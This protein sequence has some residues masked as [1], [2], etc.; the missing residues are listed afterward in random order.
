MRHDI[1]GDEEPAGQELRQGQLEIGRVA[2]SIRIEKDEVEGP[3]ETGQ[4][5]RGGETIIARLE[6][7]KG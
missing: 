1:V 3:R 4:R 7:A 5:V 6:P 2:A